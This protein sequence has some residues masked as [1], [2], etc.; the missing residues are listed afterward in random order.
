MDGVKIETRIV[1]FINKQAQQTSPHR[2]IFIDFSLNGNTFAKV[3]L[4]GYH[5]VTKTGNAMGSQFTFSPTLTPHDAEKFRK[6][7]S[8]VKSRGEGSFHLDATG[9]KSGFTM[10]GGVLTYESSYYANTMT[11]TMKYHDG[12]G[13]DLEDMA[14]TIEAYID[15]TSEKE[16]VD[17]VKMLDTMSMKM[18]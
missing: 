9:Q 4:F 18:N 1:T 16:M 14:K 17:F 10:T 7:V 12:L 11:I 8:V 3:E 13:K 15:L 6:F 5:Y 2:E